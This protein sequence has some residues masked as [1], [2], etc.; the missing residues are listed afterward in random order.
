M[1]AKR[2]ELFNGWDRSR[3]GRLFVAAPTD[4]RAVELVNGA[5]GGKSGCQMTLDYFRACWDRGWGT[6]M[7]GVTPKEGVWRIGACG[8]KPK[9]LQ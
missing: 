1:S 9:R 5:V 8:G 6:D 3:G 7:D 2:I 4:E